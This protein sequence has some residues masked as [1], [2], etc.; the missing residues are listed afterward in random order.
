MTMNFTQMVAKASE[1]LQDTTNT[2]WSTTT[3][4]NYVNDGQRDF[5]RNSKIVK[6]QS[7]PL[8]GSN[9][10][11]TPPGAFY[12]MPADMLELESVWING[13]RMYATSTDAMGWNWDTQAGQPS[14]YIYGEFGLLD[15][16]VWPYP[17]G[18]VKWQPGTVYFTGQQLVNGTNVYLCATSGTSGSAPGPISTTSPVHD[19]T[20]TWTYVG[21]APSVIVYYAALPAD[22]STGSP[23]CVLPVQYQLALAW[24]ATAQCYLMAGDYHDPSA[25][26][27]FMQLYQRELVDATGRAGRAFNADALS[28][29]YR[30]V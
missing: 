27:Q 10:F 13:Q 3:I 14:R 2:R 8:A 19:N 12:A 29:P 15:M 16:R 11:Q 26:Q 25:G 21:T 1:Y 28:V 20:V 23:T 22:M 7:P 6:E 30:H 4:G 24:Y 18:G 5:A 17:A 9:T